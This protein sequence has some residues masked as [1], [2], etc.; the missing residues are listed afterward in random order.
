[1]MDHG[2]RP[3]RV[4]PSTVVAPEVAQACSARDAL[5]S[6]KVALVDRWRDVHGRK[7]CIQP[8]YKSLELNTREQKLVCLCT[9]TDYMSTPAP[10]LQSLDSFD[11]HISFLYTRLVSYRRCCTMC[12]ATRYGRRTY[13]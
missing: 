12:S 13:F 7:Q 6:W 10:G 8:L 4:G 2:R 11:S 5:V 9:N 1:M 3:A